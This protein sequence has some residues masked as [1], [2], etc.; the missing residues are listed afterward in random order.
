M[1]ERIG[2]FKKVSVASGASEARAAWARCTPLPLLFPFANFYRHLHL[3]CTDQDP[4]SPLIYTRCNF[5][6]G[7]ILKRIR[8]FK[9]MKYDPIDALTLVPLLSVA[10]S[11]KNLS[12]SL[13]SLFDR[14][15]TRGTGCLS[16]LCSC[17]LY[18]PSSTRGLFEVTISGVA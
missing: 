9:M 14:W 5:I 18:S 12:N 3:R 13:R 4:D 15:V 8:R 11:S 6:R 17:I 10:M 7:A 1:N 16:R 2:K